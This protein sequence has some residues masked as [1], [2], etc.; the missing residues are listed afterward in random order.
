MS[1]IKKHPLFVLFFLG[2]ILRIS[3]LFIDYSFDVNNHISWAQDVFHRGLRGF[4]ETP[5]KEVYATIYPNYP[6]ASILIFYI[7]Y[8]LQDIIFNIAW[9]L[10]VH[11]PLFPSTI[12]P[13]LKQRMFL[14]GLMK[15][16]GLF[17]DIGVTWMSYMFA[18]KIVP[19][20]TKLHILAAGLILLHPT[21][22]YNSSF[23]GQIDSIPILFTLIGVYFL[24]YTKR[25]ILSSISI[26]I[27]LL[28]KPTALVYLPIYVLFFMKKYKGKEAIKIFT[29][30]LLFFWLAFV[31]FFRSGNIFFFPFQTYL[32]KI[33]EEQ[34]LSAVSNGAYTAWTMW[35]PHMYVQDST[36]LIGGLSYRLVGFIIVSIIFSAITWITYKRGLKKFDVIYAL[37][38]CS[39]TA[40][41]FLTKMHERYLIL[42]LP[43]LLLAALKDRYVLKWWIIVSAISFLNLYK[44]FAVP[45]IDILAESLNNQIVIFLF[46]L[47]NLIVY[48]YIGLRFWKRPH[49]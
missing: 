39:Y 27:A 21:F 49:T 15:L 22:I 4:Y 16:P 3:L 12:I 7:A 34:S 11:I 47:V 10:N 20:K 46:S 23:C 30:N 5:S 31:P 38:L 40:F 14:A 36:I 13:F 25:S 1:F 32:Y 18:K 35:P 42:I 43:F 9:T 45:R 33:L 28:F 24:F 44:S 29:V 48:L 6:P 17:S 19:N 8:T 26:L 2:F 37:A 41:L